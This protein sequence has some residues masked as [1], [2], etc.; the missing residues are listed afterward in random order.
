MRFVRLPESA[1]DWLAEDAVYIIT[2]EERL[3]VSVLN[4]DKER[5][6][7]MN[8]FGIGERLMSTY[9][10]TTSKLNTTAVSS[11]P[12]KIWRPTSGWKTDRGRI[13]VLFGPPDSW[14]WSRVKEHPAQHPTR[15]RHLPPPCGA[16]ALPL[17]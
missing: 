17:H 3:R 14:I 5:E 10:D 2:P 9:P 7:F 11:S 1:R 16:V 15:L 8:C 13:Y 4:T 6:Q 12:T